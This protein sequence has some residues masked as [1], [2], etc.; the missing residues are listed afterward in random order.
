[1]FVHEHSLCCV[2]SCPTI[3]T[4]VFL[5]S[6]HMH[7]QVITG[8]PASYKTASGENNIEAR[9]I[10]NYVTSGVN[11]S[12]LEN[13]GGTALCLMCM[14]SVILRA[15]WAR[16]SAV[17]VEVFNTVARACEYC[18]CGYYAWSAALTSVC[19]RT[20]VASVGCWYTRVSMITCRL[21][22]VF[23]LLANAHWLDC[24]HT[25]RRPCWRAHQHRQRRPSQQHQPGRHRQHAAP[26]AR[27]TAR[28]PR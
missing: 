20:I 22:P 25:L 27:R 8:S 6:A 17:L 10:Y 24:T 23:N 2:S 15:N 1:M 18:I 3:L 14:R 26:H 9:E 16:A 11:A 7:L 19:V 4:S 28:Q 12:L 21:A 13:G 5:L